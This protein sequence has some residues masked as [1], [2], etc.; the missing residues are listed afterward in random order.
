MSKSYILFQDDLKNKQTQISLQNEIKILKDEIYILNNKLKEYKL[1]EENND[2]NKNKLYSIFLC[3][4]IL[5]FVYMLQFLD[6]D[7]YN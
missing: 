1:E 2:S 4:I 7:Y 3:S 5:L 6:D